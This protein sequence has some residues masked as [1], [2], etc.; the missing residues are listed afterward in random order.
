MT[1]FGNLLG[2]LQQQQEE[3][4]RKLAEFKVQAEAGDGAVKVTASA[5]RQILDISFDKSKF[6]WEDTEQLQDFLLTAINRALALAEEKE[7]EEAQ[8]LVKD[9]LPSGLGGLSGMFK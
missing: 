9:I 8:K 1:M 3:M 6:D 4:K 5:N 2:N 7:K